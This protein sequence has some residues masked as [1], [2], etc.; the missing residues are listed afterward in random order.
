M[1][2]RDG[3]YVIGLVYLDNGE[4]KDSIWTS[5]GVSKYVLV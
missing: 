2:R 1:Q 4:Y 3:N 5:L